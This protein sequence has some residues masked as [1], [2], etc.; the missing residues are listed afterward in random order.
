M[1]PH[2]Q[3]DIAQSEALPSNKNTQHSKRPLHEREILGVMQRALG[4]GTII[5]L[6]IA[7]ILL[8]FLFRPAGQP[9]SRYLGEI[10]GTTAILL[11]SCSLVLATKAPFLERAFGGLD[12]MY[13][14][15]PDWCSCSCGHLFQ[16]Y[17]SLVAAFARTTSVGSRSTG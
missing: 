8:W 7:T 11:F 6:T 5:G 1:Y 14:W 4:G 12:R 15:H 16:D 9:T 17:L 13:L 10:L 2:E 3:P